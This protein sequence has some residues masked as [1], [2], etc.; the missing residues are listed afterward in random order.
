MNRYE[1]NYENGIMAALLCNQKQSRE[2]I[3][4]VYQKVLRFQACE[5]EEKYGP[6][7]L[8]SKWHE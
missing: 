6:I 5:I 2:A 1:K 3:I 8:Q 7:C 4:N